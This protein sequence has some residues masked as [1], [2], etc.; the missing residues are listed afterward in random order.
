MIIH[1]LPRVLKG[2]GVFA[3]QVVNEVM[4]VIYVQ[5]WENVTYEPVCQQKVLKSI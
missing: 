3:I 2:F 4:L 1:G 5:C